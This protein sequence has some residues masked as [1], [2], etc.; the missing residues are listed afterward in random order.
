MSKRKTDQKRNRWTAEEDNWLIANHPHL[1][2]EL[3]YPAFCEVFGERH[4]L[5]SYRTRTKELHLHVTPERWRS[6]CKNNGNRDN[7]PVGTLKVRGRGQVWVKVAD[8]TAG[9]M[10]LAQAIMRPRPGEIVVHLD[11]DKENNDPDN[12]MA[13]SRSVLA[14][15]SRQHFWSED[16]NI[17]KT[18]I[19]CCELELLTKD[20]RCRNDQ[21][22]KGSAV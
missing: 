13:V 2:H 22:R 10:P 9:W 12:L 15:M 4:P 19:L 7:V 6:A 18:G 14:R 3:G 20:R 21:W 11:G 16:P 17:T 1:G 8:G 5:S